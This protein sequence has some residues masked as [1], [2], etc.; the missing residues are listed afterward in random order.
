M[1]ERERCAKIA[2]THPRVVY[3]FAPHNTSG[4]ATP[5]EAG[6]RDIAAKIRGQSASEAAREELA[7][8]AQ[9]LDMGYGAPSG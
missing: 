9:E 7:K 5:R 3:Y 2:E 6:F 4:L 1:E 8:Q